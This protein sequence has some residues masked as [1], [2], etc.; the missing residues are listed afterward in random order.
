[1][2][3][4]HR[5]HDGHVHGKARRLELL[6][7]RGGEV[8]HPSISSTNPAARRHLHHPLDDPRD[9]AG[10]PV[11]LAAWKRVRPRLHVLLARA[12]LDAGVLAWHAAS[13]ALLDG[14]RMVP[15]WWS[16]L[17]ERQRARNTPVR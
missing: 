7:G 1:M 6:P 5:V 16:D 12:V 4:V 11:R 3:S 17:N 14:A 10:D 9:L 13:A 15:S 2:G 8:R